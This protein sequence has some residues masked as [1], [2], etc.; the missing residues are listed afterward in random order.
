[1][2]YKSKTREQLPS[3]QLP[4]ETSALV[5]FGKQMTMLVNAKSF[6]GYPL[7]GVVTGE[8]GLGKTVSCI[9]FA[10]SFAP[11]LHTQ[12][13][14]CI[15]LKIPPRP[16]PDRVS[17]VVAASLGIKVDATAGTT[18]VEQAIEIIAASDIK[19]MI[20]DEADW[21]DEECFEILRY[22]HDEAQ[23]SI[24]VVGLDNLVNVIRSKEK[25]RSRVGLRSSFKQLDQSEILNTVLPQLVFP[26]WRFDP[27][28]SQDVELGTYIWDI[29][30]PS[31]RRLRKLLQAASL[32]T[33]SLGEQRI[34]QN[35]IELTLRMTDFSEEEE[36][37]ASPE[38]EQGELERESA[39]RNR[40]KSRLKKI[41][42]KDPAQ[43]CT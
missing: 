12:L 41:K 37:E 5:L 31:F 30:R 13:P 22:I 27:T 39:R 40:R 9:S 24:A 25:F 6:T 34:D 4:I 35:I 23:I 14:A 19:L 15:Y 42:T 26:H 29:V 10:N 18:P 8:A 11:Q 16:T 33:H 2:F 21:L 7:M 32:I 36:N 17:A 1:M 28:N 20:A 43:L 3:N 38:D